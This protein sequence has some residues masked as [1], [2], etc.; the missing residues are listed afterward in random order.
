MANATGVSIV[1]SSSGMTRQASA[2]S[3]NSDTTRA[4]II[5]AAQ[6][7]FSQKGYSHAGM[8]EI[9]AGAEVAVSL[10]TKHFQTKANLYEQALVAAH[11]PAADFQ[12]DRAGFGRAVA[13]S[14]TQAHDRIAAPA[15]IALSLGDAE[16]S[17]IAARV[18]RDHILA[19]MASWLGGDGLA[20]ATNVLMMTMGFAILYQRLPLGHSQEVRRL[21]ARLFAN[22]LQS[23]VDEA[24]EPI[25]RTGPAA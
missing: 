20:R 12:G 10:L 19:P 9:A 4:R 16:A 13:E 8:R 11:I 6:A 22:A 15:M 24:A 3:R 7:V 25:T 1:A 5:A 21:T 23:I 14:I 18:T 17:E 2:S